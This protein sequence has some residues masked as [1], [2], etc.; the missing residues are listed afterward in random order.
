MEWWQTG[1]IYQIYP[2]SFQDGNGDGVGDLTGIL[3]R[4]DYLS[5]TLGVDAVWLSPFY[6]SPMDDF[7]YDISDY[8]DVDPLFGGLDDFDRLLEAFHDR[9]VRVIVDLV[10]NHTSDR[11]PWF[12]ESRSGRDHPRREWY[13]WAD[14]GPDGGPPNNWLA[15]FGGVAWEWDESTGQYYLHSFLRSQPDLNWRNPE[16]EAAMFDVMRFWLERGVDGFRLDVAHFVMKDPDLR[17]NPVIEPGVGA[18]KDMAEYGTQD[19]LYDKGHPDVHPLFRR[20]RALLDGYRSPRVAIGE[21]HIDDYRQW[22]AYYG[23]DRD[24]LHLPFNFRLLYADWQADAIGAL[25]DELEAALP[26]GAWPNYVLG[27]HDEPRLAT[28]FGPENRRLAAMLLLTLR[29]T[30][31]LYYGDELGLFEVEIPPDRQV[32]PWGLQVPGLGRD[33]CRTPMPWD[34]TPGAGFTRGEPWLPLGPQAAAMHVAAQLE[35]PGSVLNLYRALLGLRRGMPSLHR[36]GYRRIEAPAGVLGYRR[37]APGA[38]PVAVM[39]NFT[40]EGQVVE[41][42]G[43]IALSTTMNRTGTRSA[44]SIILAPHEGIVIVDR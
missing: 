24:E 29:G 30:P 42:A 1:V 15:A 8:C 37:E 11:H 18:F 44:G 31:T 39:L 3:G 35:D 7:G 34:G 17:D 19:H 43:E 10:P 16:V 22:A 21:I 6:R 40:G 38:A 5:E 25:V 9:G 4:V 23:A 26:T 20:M 33:G 36:G 28:R 2:R 14:P 41:A 12:L 27:N 32:D 13:V